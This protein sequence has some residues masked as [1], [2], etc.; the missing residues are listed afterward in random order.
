MSR[1]TER[2]TQARLYRFIVK[3]LL[4]IKMRDGSKKTGGRMKVM[5]DD[6]GRAI[7]FVVGRLILIND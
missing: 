1:R 2:R 3:L 7:A 4:V 6:M 5:I